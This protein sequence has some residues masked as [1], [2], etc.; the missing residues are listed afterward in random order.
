MHVAAMVGLLGL[1]GGLY[2]PVRAM[3]DHTFDFNSVP[4]RLQLAM[5]GLCLAFVLM[6]VQSFINA[7]RLRVR[8]VP[9]T[10]HD[11]DAH[12]VAGAFEI[13]AID[14]PSCGRF[15]AGGLLQNGA[16][17]ISGVTRAGN[18]SLQT[19]I[20]SPGPKA[21]RAFS[22]STSVSAAD[23]VRQFSTAGMQCLLL[24]A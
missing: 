8:R 17:I 14:Q 18:P 20:Q 2:R 22:G 13:G 12:I 7:R 24:L 4:T 19:T 3:I 6:C 23:G 15:R 10:A 21:S 16:I 9:T 11:D 5:A 1:I